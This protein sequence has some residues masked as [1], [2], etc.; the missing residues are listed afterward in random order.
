MVTL[1]KGIPVVAAAVLL[2]AV[3]AVRTGS[4]QD[5]IRLQQGW[6]PDREQTFYYTPQCT[7][8]MP[9]SWLRALEAADG[10]PVMTPEHMRRLG[11]LYD[12]RTA[13]GNP[14][15]WPIGFAVDSGAKFGGV[16]MVGLTCAACHTSEIHY[17]GSVVRVDGGQANIDLDAFKR[18]LNEALLKTGSDPARK[19]AFERRAAEFGFPQD[20]IAAA[21]EQRYQ[22][23]RAGLPERQAYLAHATAAGP[24]RNDALAAIALQV[25][26]YDIGVSTNTNVASAPVDYPFLWDIGKL[27]WVQYNASVHQPMS[28][29]IGEALGVGAV[30]NIVN[31][32]TRDVNPEPLR[33]QTSIPPANLYGIETA[34]ESLKPPVW[35]AHVFGA[36]DRAKVEAGRALFAEN[37]ASCHGV[38][39]LTGSKVDEWSVKVLPLK[40]IGTDAHQADNFAKDTYDAT[41]LGLSKTTTAAVGLGVVTNAVR[42]QAY[43]D[44]KIPPAYWPQYDGFGRKNVVTAPCGYKARPLVG[45]WATPP[46]LHNGS[47]PTIFALLSDSRPATFRVGT[48]EYDPVRLGFVDASGP[49]AMTIDTSIAG[50]SNAGHWF[51]DD[52]ARPG[53]IGRALS[54]TERYALI[55]YLK[56]ASYADYPRTVVQRPDPE[57]CVDDAKA[58]R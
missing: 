24:G 27:N 30:T 38:R 4:T 45:V 34:I 42:E 53:R 55:E 14:Y 19:A 37:C 39:A 17:R 56:A 47:V 54:V 57:P 41:K 3:A 40:V 7:A 29:N 9:V 21:F 1:S 58:Y 23:L 50:N 36:T 2:A 11:F 13:A 6:S 20:R 52:R 32:A 5:V 28:R 33:W 48:T 12:G 31:P 49:N 44:A 51:T 26:N 16:P 25:F 18:L 10:K 46:F 43:K 8:I 35:P 22:A 15:N